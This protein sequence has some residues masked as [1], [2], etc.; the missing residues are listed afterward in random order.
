MGQQGKFK[1]LL[2]KIGNLL[3]ADQGDAIEDIL[4]SIRAIN[5]RLQ[6]IEAQ[7]RNVQS[8]LS[9]LAAKQ[10]RVN[11]VA[12]GMAELCAGL[13]TRLN[14]IEAVQREILAAAP[15]GANAFPQE[16]PAHIQRKDT[17]WPR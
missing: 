1:L 11:T 6:T 13:E 14:A 8:S 7:Q 10:V 4:D 16:F 17:G 5:L 9:N 15:R 2:K 12:S 3:F